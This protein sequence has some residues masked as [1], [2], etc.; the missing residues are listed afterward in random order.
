MAWIMDTYSMGMGRP[1]PGVVTGKPI[2]LGGS[3]GRE[4]ATS[5]GCVYTILS[6]L[7]VLGIDNPTLDIVIQGFGNVGSNCA[8]ILFDLGHRILAVSDVSGGLYSKAGI[9]PYKLLEHIKSG[10]TL[11][12]Y[13]KAQAIPGSDIF[14]V[15]CDVLIPAAFENQITADNAAKIKTKIIAEGANGPVTPDADSILKDNNIFIIPDILCN[16]G[17]VTVSYF[18]WVQGNL[19]YFWGKREVNLKL[20]D[21]I[22]KAFYDVYNMHKKKNV[23]MRNAASFIAV[24]RVAESIILRGIYP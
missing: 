18:E 17:G 12:I 14:E 11:S 9:D 6:T 7:K 2:S 20:R 15:K 3:K 19:A 4:D 21:I 23:D 22:E 13:N 5:R 8:K 24:Q 16:A 1:V 10:Q